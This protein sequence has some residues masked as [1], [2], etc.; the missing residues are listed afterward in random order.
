MIPIRE[1]STQKPAYLTS[2][3]IDDQVQPQ[4]PHLLYLRDEPLSFSIGKPPSGISYPLISEESEP[5]LTEKPLNSPVCI[6]T[7]P[8]HPLFLP[9][10]QWRTGR[11]V[12]KKV[13][14]RQEEVTKSLTFLPCAFRFSSALYAIVLQVPRTLPRARCSRWD[15]KG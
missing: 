7:Q 12:S 3:G 14:P 5:L 9:G 2:H 13:F 8:Y 10:G 4:L 11:K 6:S 15:L 1:L